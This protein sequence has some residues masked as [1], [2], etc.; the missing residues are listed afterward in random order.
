[1]INLV[2]NKTVL[3]STFVVMCMLA[4]VYWFG[5]VLAN[6]K[7]LKIEHIGVQGEVR[8]ATAKA[9]QDIIKQQ[10]SGNLVTID[11]VNLHN[12]VKALPAIKTAQIKRVGLNR[13]SIAVEE[14]Q[15]IAVWSD[16]RF[17]SK[18]GHIFHAEYTGDLSLPQFE[19]M[20]AQKDWLTAMYV[21]MQPLL[22][23]YDFELKTLV[24]KSAN[25]LKL[26]FSNHV[27]VIMN[28]KNWLPRLRAFCAVYQS[29]IQKFGQGV[30]ADLRY[31]N[32][33]SLKKVR[34]L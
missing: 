6:H 20:E 9:L 13:L 1:M 25:T 18:E 27:E 24:V 23:E 4:V 10:L 17:V 19:A 26:V 14:Y 28:K 12:S 8:P 29:Q 32:G 3:L 31:P 2:T 34:V 15:P 33:F 5:H 22:E 16:E 30:F 11:I 21:E 7:S